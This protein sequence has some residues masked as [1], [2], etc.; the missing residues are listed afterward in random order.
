MTVSLEES[1]KIHREQMDILTKRRER[2]EAKEK[3][4]PME[5]KDYKSTLREISIVEWLTPR[6]S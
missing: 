6:A 5:E 2:Y 4:N 3:R 1:M